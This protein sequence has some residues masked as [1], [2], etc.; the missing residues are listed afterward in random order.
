MWITLYAWKKTFWLLELQVKEFLDSWMTNM[1]TTFGFVL[2]LQNKFYDENYVTIIVLS[3]WT[4]YEPI[5]LDFTVQTLILVWVFLSQQARRYK[6]FFWWLNLAIWAHILP[7][8]RGEISWQTLLVVI[9]LL[10]KIKRKLFSNVSHWK[11][12]LN[13][14]LQNSNDQNDWKSG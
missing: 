2:K 12:Q 9:F 4:E 14:F 13:P 7:R 10:L 6:S 5:W 8:V 3:F 1:W 11:K